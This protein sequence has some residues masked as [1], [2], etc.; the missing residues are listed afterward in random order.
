M[1]IRA[2]LK[3]FGERGNEALLKELR[4]IHD[5][6]AMVPKKKDDLTNEDR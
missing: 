6:K 5:R 3:K 1:C 2:G 4:Q